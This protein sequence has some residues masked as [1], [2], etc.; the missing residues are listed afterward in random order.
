MRYVCSTNDVCGVNQSGSTALCVS[1]IAT[2]RLVDLQWSGIHAF[3]DKSAATRVNTTQLT[4]RRT[5][6]T[7]W[8]HY[9]VHRIQILQY[10]PSL[11]GDLENINFYLFSSV[12]L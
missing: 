5:V 9:E 7:F 6:D 3:S 12:V 4:N 10:L 1:V 8:I 11:C 2:V